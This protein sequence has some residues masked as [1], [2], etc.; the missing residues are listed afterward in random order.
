[1]A[2]KQTAT[3]IAARKFGALVKDHAVKHD[4]RICFALVF[5]KG[6]EI[7]NLAGEQS[8]LAGNTYN[9]G[10]FHGMSCGRDKSFDYVDKDHGQLYAVS[11]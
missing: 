7:A 5:F 10:W 1:M 8:Q 2:R 4:V 9:G 3:Q 6:A 11:Y